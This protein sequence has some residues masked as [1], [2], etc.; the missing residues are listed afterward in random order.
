MTAP[1][2]VEVVRYRVTAGVETAVIGAELARA[3]FDAHPK[4]LRSGKRDGAFI[5]WDLDELGRRCAP[6]ICKPVSN[7]CS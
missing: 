3:A 7:L 6:I 1:A 4:Q 5:L 2:Y